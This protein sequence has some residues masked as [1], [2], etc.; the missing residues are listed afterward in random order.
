M[1]Y[2]LRNLISLSVDII[3]GTTSCEFCKVGRGQE[4]AA[5]FAVGLCHTAMANLRRDRT[6]YPDKSTQHRSHKKVNQTRGVR[7]GCHLLMDL[8]VD[9]RTCLLHPDLR[10]HFQLEHRLFT[11]CCARIHTNKCMENQVFTS[12]ILEDLV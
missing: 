3:R 11:G 5:N 4:L 12:K 6:R 8:L 7:R 9:K 1:L 2:L 10:Q